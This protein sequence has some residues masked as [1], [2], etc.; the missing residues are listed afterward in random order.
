MLFDQHITLRLLHVV[1]LELLRLWIDMHFLTS[2]LFDLLL[3]PVEF[4]NTRLHV[5]EFSLKAQDSP[6]IVH[7]SFDAGGSQIESFL[8]RAA[9]V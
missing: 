9:H 7:A 6:S 2:L 5:C 8:K 3:Q 1:N 4:I